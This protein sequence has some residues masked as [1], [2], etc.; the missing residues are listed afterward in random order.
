M[1]ATEGLVTRYFEVM[2]SLA[3]NTAVT[4]VE[5]PGGEARSA[6]LA[7]GIDAFLRIGRDAHA[8][9]RKLILIGNGASA[10]LASH[11]ASDFSKNAGIRAM[12]VTDGA[13]L[14]ALVNDIGAEAIFSKQIDFYAQRGDVLV[15][16]SSSGS[17]PNI[18][19]AVAAAR[20]R[21][22]AVVS[23]SG[24]DPENPLRRSGDLNFHV[25]ADE[26]GFVEVTHT[27]LIHAI[28]DLS[29]GWG[30]DDDRN[31]GAMKRRSMKSSG[32]AGRE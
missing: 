13:M 6:G 1:S 7:E 28:L 10:S 32:A 20:D 11:F 25:P 23:F 17:S 19:A 30:T 21:G 5:T 22:C 4:I 26:Y 15:A 9:D 14:T 12:S 31:P 27:A 2:N 8:R 16:I 24:F 18:L 29:L 3:T